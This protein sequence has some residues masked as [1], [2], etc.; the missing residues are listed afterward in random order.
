LHKTKQTKAKKNKAKQNKTKQTKQKANTKTNVYVWPIITWKGLLA[1]LSP[2][3]ISEFPHFE[4]LEGC[5][6]SA[7]T[8][9]G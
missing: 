7:G 8:A 4:E 5:S 1:L 6:L 9:E 3:Y 2:R